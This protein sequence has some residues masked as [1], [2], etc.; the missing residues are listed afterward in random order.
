MAAGPFTARWSTQAVKTL[1]TL[2]QEMRKSINEGCEDSVDWVRS[3]WVKG[4]GVGGAQV[5]AVF[6]MGV[7]RVG[8]SGVEGDCSAVSGGKRLPGR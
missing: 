4:A 3:P 8:A 5:C 1:V 2:E 7:C 6:G